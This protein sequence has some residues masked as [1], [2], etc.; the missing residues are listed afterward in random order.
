MLRTLRTVM[1]QPGVVPM[2]IGVNTGKVFTGDFG[3]P[4]RRAYRVFG[5]AI[6]TA[7]RV[8][9]KAEAG[10]I[11]S[12]EIVLNRS[13]TVFEATPIPPFAA[14]GKAEPVR[15]S[16]VGPV[17]GTRE[18]ERTALPLAGR[19]A[20]LRALLDAVET[21]RAGHGMLVEMIGEP[22]IGKTRLLDEVVARSPDFRILRTRGEEYESAT[23]YFAMRAV[24]RSA[25]DLDP[26][27]DT[28]EVVARL[29]LV[30]ES[31]EPS[32]VPLDPAAR[33]PARPRPPADARDRRP[34]RAVPARATGRG[35]LDVPAPGAAGPDVPR[36]RRQPPSRRIDPRPRA[37]ALPGGRRAPGDGRPH[38]PGVRTGSSTR[39]SWRPSAAC[40]SG[41]SPSRRRRRLELV[42]IATEDEPLR[43]HEAEMVAERS[44][45]NP[46]FL[47]ELLDAVRASGLRGVAAGFGRGPDRGPDRSAGADRP[48]DPPLRGGAR[49]PLRSRAARGGGPLRR[50]AGRRRLGSP[51]GR[52]DPGSGRQPPVRE[53]PRSGRRVRGAAVPASPGAPRA[54]RR[55]RSRRPPASPS[56][57]RSRP[58]RSTST[59]PSAGTSRGRTAGWPATGR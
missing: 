38:P 16:I 15:A 20:E 3:P 31:I 50:R 5:D 10:Q 46:M 19:D 34:R 58:S 7:A 26:A 6:N 14:K 30:V 52:P 49:D 32:L 13:K 35:R 8:M 29:G 28:S 27:A 23:P 21:T 25:L 37:P 51:V 55:R 2:R 53:Q 54:R 48:D 39:T 56:R 47:M 43:P 40:S 17:I 57:R 44:G 18:D 24:M 59:R 11:L 36:D 42:E 45:G 22:G 12:T 41:S 4:Y 1:E 33:R 9:A